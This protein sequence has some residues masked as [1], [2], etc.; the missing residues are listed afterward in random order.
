[1][2][3]KMDA[4]LDCNDVKDGSK[5]YEEENYMTVEDKDYFSSLLGVLKKGLVNNKEGAHEILRSQERNADE[6]DRAVDE[7]NIYVKLRAYN[8]DQKV[9]QQINHSLKRLKDPGNAYGYC[10]ECGIEIGVERLKMYPATD[11]CVE[12][13]ALDELEQKRKYA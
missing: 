2:E 5:T 8:R 12:C 13:K 3:V 11:F 9:I 1:M 7:E 4:M 10:N 6:A